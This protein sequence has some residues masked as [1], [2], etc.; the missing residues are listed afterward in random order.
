MA[1]LVPVEIDAIEIR[2][3]AEILGIELT[4]ARLVQVQHLDQAYVD[5]RRLMMAEEPKKR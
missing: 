4:P 3:I 1:G 2:T 5:E